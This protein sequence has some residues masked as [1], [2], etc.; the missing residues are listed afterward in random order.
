M[1]GGNPIFL[2]LNQTCH[3]SGFALEL[4]SPTGQWKLSG[5]QD[6]YLKRLEGIKYKTMVSDDYD[7]IVIAISN[8]YNDMHKEEDHN[9]PYCHKVFKFQK[10]L[11]KHLRIKHEKVI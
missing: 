6:E 8:Y 4:K 5:K 1:S 7:E 11:K 3:Y 10:A 2:I 9:C